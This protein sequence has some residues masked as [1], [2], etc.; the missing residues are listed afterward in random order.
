MEGSYQ[1]DFC[2]DNGDTIHLHGIIDNTQLSALDGQHLDDSIVAFI[3]AHTE[4]LDDK[5]YLKAIQVYL[6]NGHSYTI[7]TNSIRQNETQASFLGN[8]MTSPKV[9]RVVWDLERVEPQ[10]A[11]ILGFDIASSIDLSKSFCSAQIYDMNEIVTEAIRDP[12]LLRQ[13]HDIEKRYIEKSILESPFDECPLADTTLHYSAIK[14]WVVSA[15]Y[16][17][18]K[19]KLVDS[20]VNKDL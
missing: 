16:D 20:C 17:Y 9:T 7:L 11:K 2:F 18:A 6:N 19:L 14:G 1:R 15:V 12:G 8:I 4:Q 10:L 5:D 3:V 13:Y